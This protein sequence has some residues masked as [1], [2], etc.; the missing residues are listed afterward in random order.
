MKLP[1]VQA[2]LR[3][4]GRTLKR[5][6]FVLGCAALGAMVAL[7]IIDHEGPPAP[8]VLFRI[9]FATVLGL[10][11]LTAFTL[12]AEKRAWGKAVSTGV[13]V[14]G[15]L[16]LAAYTFSVP[17]DLFHAPL[18]HLQRLVMLALALCGLVVIGPFVQAGQSNGFWHYSKILFFRILLAALYSA[19][20]F[21]GLA[22]AL[23]ALDNLFGMDV[24]GKRYGELWVLIIGVFA[25]WFFLAGVPEDLDRLDDETDYPKGLKVFAQ[26]VLLPLLSVYLVILYAYLTKIIVQWSWPQGWV[27]RLTL[28]FAGAGISTLL[29]LQPIREKTENMWIRVATRWFWVIM[30]PPIVMLMLAV[31]RRISEYGITE[32]RY[33]AFG[34][35][36]WLAA[37]VIYFTISRTK[38]IK[39]IPGS[40]CLLS[41]LM[42]FGPWGVFH[43]SEA[44]QVKRLDRILAANE[45]LVGGKVQSAPRAVSP[46]D[47]RQISSIV[48]YLHEIHG[49]DRIQ[50]WFSERLMQDSAGAGLRLTDPAI[51]V[52]T[53]GV[54]YDRVAVLSGRDAYELVA[55]P[56]RTISLD[57]YERM[58][59]GQRI[60]A[61]GPKL[62]A[63]TGEISYRL[64]SSFNVLTVIVMVEGKA[65]D[66]LA[67]DLRPLV[68]TLVRDYGNVG[69]GI[70]PPEKMSITAATQKLKLKICLRRIQFR[71]DGDE[72]RPA[73][74]DADILYSIAG[75]S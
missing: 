49:Y 61:A 54:E 2:T 45:I 73:A 25:T 43:V 65:V 19:T 69:G 36:I 32:G 15:L 39:V 58:L 1:S 22:I 10:P 51:V 63:P 34:L 27:S 16:L 5:F 62:E 30:I 40:L 56:M 48:S 20:L 44:S 42:S 14:L 60:R 38:T 37:M 57:G 21:A 72:T 55:D 52:K 68:D 23:A 24:P 17:L 28:S 12:I 47:S 9:L 46:A 64:D 70:I 11:L 4:S 6:P 50:P 35:G 41:L 3:E 13:Q 8:T 53:M 26:Y 18:V 74:Y 66:S 71:K 29:L 31:A 7:I 59:P 75:R 67:V 33:I